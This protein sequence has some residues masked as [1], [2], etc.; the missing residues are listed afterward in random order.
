MLG[1]L[2]EAGYPLTNDPSRAEILIVNTCGFIAS[3]KEES[4]NTLL[5]MA[6]YKSD[7][8][9]RILIAAGCLVQRYA[10]DLREQMPEV[11][12]FVGVSE[13][14][15]LTAIIDSLREAIRNADITAEDG[16]PR[17]SSAVAVSAVDMDTPVFECAPF[18]ATTPGA[19]A[20]VRIADGCDNR[21][22]YCAIPMI[23]GPYRSRSVESVLAETAR[24]VEDGAR[25]VVFIA[26]DT[27]RFGLKVGD[28]AERSRL[29]I[30]L[31]RA[32]RLPGEP[33]VRTMY[34]HPARV[35][36]ELLETLANTP[37]VCPY[38]DVPL[39]HVDRDVLRRMNRWG[40]PDSILK[41]MEKARSF[42]LTLRTTFL[43]G[44]PGEDEAAFRRL[45]EFAQA[46]QF[47]R[48]G[49]FAFSP[50]EDTPAF[51]M[52]NQVPESVAAERLDALMK[53]QRGISLARN[54]LRVGETA[55]VL[56]EGLVTPKE[57]DRRHEPPGILYTG[58]SKREAPE[59]DGVILVR[60]AEPLVVGGFA[61]IRITRAKA[62]D[63]EGVPI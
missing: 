14:P 61:T 19:F 56:I 23:R 43:V 28:G 54:K 51:D 4:V 25:E 59:C 53:L 33:W 10:K 34:C 29:P 26:Q 52:P 12:A 9:C 46:F 35:T 50:E 1:L 2:R 41:L 31:A 30:L 6:R 13:Y 60:S 32:S 7:G 16:K 36:D 57:S 58:R 5:D 3:A 55:P 42:G 48:M 8:V 49:A 15:R 63:L 45:Y 22:A 37:G 38:L 21:C 47:D 27:T 11:D 39:Q 62:Y 20:Y 17:Y 24:R 18:V 40:D 44:F